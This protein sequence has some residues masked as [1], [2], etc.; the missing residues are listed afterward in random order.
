MAFAGFAP[1]ND[2]EST[3]SLSLDVF[4]YPRYF[5]AW[6]QSILKWQNVTVNTKWLHEGLWA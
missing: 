2:S 4:Y 3:V 1:A 5:G 6:I